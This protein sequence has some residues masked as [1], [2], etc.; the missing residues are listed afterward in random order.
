MKIFLGMFNIS[1]LYVEYVK[2]FRALGHEVFSVD[3]QWPSPI[4][5]DSCTSMQIHSLIRARLRAE[6]NFSEQRAQHW[7]NHYYRLAWQKALEADVCLFIWTTFRNS[8]YQD[9]AQLKQM[10]KKV[11]VRLVGSECR[12]EEVDKQHAGLNKNGVVEI[13]GASSLKLMQQRLFYLRSVEKY[14]DLI[15]GASCSSLRPSLQSFFNI[16]LDDIAYNPEPNHIP[17]LLHAPSNNLRKGSPLWQEAFATLKK[18]GIK[19]EERIIQGLT[20]SQF[21]QEYAKADINCGGIF[22]GGKAELEAMAGG[23]L[24]LAARVMWPPAGFSST[25]SYISYLSDYTSE[26]LGIER[27][28]EDYKTIRRAKGAYC[29]TLSSYLNLVQSVNPTNLVDVLKYW[30]T[31]HDKRRAQIYAGRQ[32]VENYCSPQKQCE[33]ILD[34]VHQPE[35]LSSHAQLNNIFDEFFYRHYDP[36]NSQDWLNTLNAGNLIVQDCAWYKQYIKPMRRNGLV[37]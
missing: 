37:F 36:G 13:K 20:H 11:I 34:M 12:V 16:D 4:I 1:S 19:F 23:C 22:F 6:N 33:Q 15:L 17:V 24:P 18:Q 5:D 21:V 32:F 3:I 14:A 30:I 26:A 31:N 7:W 28:S 9:L 25:A 29:H 35:E 8:D 10:G 27:G 2:G